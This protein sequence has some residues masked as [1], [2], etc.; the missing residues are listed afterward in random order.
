MRF[1][2]RLTKEASVGFSAAL[3]ATGLSKHPEDPDFLAHDASLSL[4]SSSIE[5][6]LLQLQSFSTH[7]QAAATASDIIQSKLGP[8]SV[9][10]S[11]VLDLT[12]ALTTAQLPS[13]VLEPL[14]AFQQRIDALV[15][16]RR[17]RERNRKLSALE[18]TPGP[19]TAKYE[20]YHAAFL[21]GVDALA[22]QHAVLLPQVF[23]AH[24]Q[25]LF[26]YGNA[27]Y[28]DAA[29]PAPPSE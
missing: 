15:R 14:L 6:V 21:R 13:R 24:F 23:V 3:N 7:I 29:P 27:I 4:F 26:E 5:S 22:V 11:R 25:L 28:V 20:R 2:G 18:R 16:I 8:D 17:K 9:P 1:L 10:S 19:R 12:T